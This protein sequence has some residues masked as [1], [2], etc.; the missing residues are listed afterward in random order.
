MNRLNNKVAIITGAGSG[1]GRAAAELFTQE[2]AAVVIAELDPEKANAAAAAIIASGGR[3]LAIATDI[4]EDESVSAMVRQTVEHFGTLDILYNNAGGSSQRD[5]PVTDVALSEFWRTMK[6]DLW[7]TFL[8][9]RHA[10]PV[11]IA[12]GGGTIVNTSSMVAAFGRTGA[13][14]YTAAKG[15]VSALT[16]AMAAEYGGNKIRVNAVAPGITRSERVEA[17][18]AAGR[19]RQSE[20][21]RHK[22]GLPEPID[23]AMA[24]L[25][26]ASEESRRVTGYILPVDSGMTAF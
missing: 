1:I 7:G 9:A 21:D 26:L 12:N 25:Y 24:A 13:H 10:I 19:I 11:M 22:L 8:C 6:V 16:R 23:V 20:L 5:G 17:R 18:L 15:G 14:S 3:A 4:T 2:G